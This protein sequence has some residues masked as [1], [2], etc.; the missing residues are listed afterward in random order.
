MGI[1]RVFGVIT[2][3][4]L[5]GSAHGQADWTIHTDAI[6]ANDAA[7]Q[8]AVE[9][10]TA[11]GDT[12]G[13]TFTRSTDSPSDYRRRVLVGD[14]AAP[15]I[16]AVSVDHPQG[17]VIQTVKTPKRHTIAITGGSRIGEVYGLYWLLDRMRV[18]RAMPD[19]NVRREPTLGIRFTDARNPQE[20]RDALRLTINWTGGADLLH[21]VPWNAEPEATKNAMTRAS[22][23]NLIDLAHAYHMKYFALCDEFSYHPSLLEEF[24][25]KPDIGDPA[26]WDALQAKYRRLLNAMPGIDGIRIRTGELTRVGGNYVPLDIMHDDFEVDW[27]LEERYRTFVQK[28]H[29]VVVGEFDK[30]Y[31]QRT[32]STT[33]SEQHSDPVVYRNTFTDEVPTKNLYTSP[34]LSLADRWYYQPYN[35]TFN[36]TPHN[37]VVLLAP[38]DYHGHNGI[39][40]FPSFPGPYHQG[41]IQHILTDDNSNLRGAQ[42]GNSSLDVFDTSGMTAY[43][44]FRLAW[45]PNEDLHTIAHDF[46][47]MQLGPEAADTM[48][49]I[50]LLSPV[51]YTDGIYIKP[52]AEALRGNTLPHL[53]VG[54]FPRPGIPEIDGGK[55][56]LQWLETT[57][58]EPSKGQTD[59]AIA[60]LT[61]GLDAAKAMETKLE[62]VRD[63]IDPSRVERVANSVRLTRLLVETNLFYVQTC[64]DYFKYRDRASDNLREALSDSLAVLTES[65]DAFAAAPDFA[66]TLYGIDQL[67]DGAQALLADRDATIAR[68]DRAPD[69]AQVAVLIAEQQRLHAEAS[70]AHTAKATK[71]LHWRGRIDGRDILSIRGDQFTITH[72]RHD[73]IQSSTPT[74][75]NPLPEKPITVILNTKESKPIHPFVLQQPTAANNYTAQIYVYNQPPGYDWWDFELCYVDEEPSEV[76]LSIPWQQD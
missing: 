35:P 48:A 33:A 62:Q 63:K 19:L 21:F 40:T 68:L 3:V 14:F 1:I 26:M 32:W 34:Y 17:F 20:M 46:A 24:N 42:F 5:A 56:H 76:G 25:A 47:A 49:D 7:V 64:F 8:A 37:M 15:G 69:E 67:I 38:L 4:V 39:N 50:T 59:V 43:T 70:E 16:K 9:D 6:G 65:R 41:G 52:V 66:F 53:R 75:T 30:I 73:H 36:Q 13:R 44:I 2:T 55:A 29:E 72:I 60:Y 28:M 45:D 12:L 74:F 27:S 22:H 11:F 10:I 18:Q 71:V 23:Q 57:M 54:S 51:A 61:K 58:Y 31:F